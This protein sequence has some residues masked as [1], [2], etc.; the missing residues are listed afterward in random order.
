LAPLP[1]GLPASASRE[2]PLGGAQPSPSTQLAHIPPAPNL[3]T[4]PLP[5]LRTR[6]AVA[7]GGDG[8]PDELGMGH[9][10]DEA[11]AMAAAAWGLLPGALHAPVLF[12][13]VAGVGPSGACALPS[14]FELPAFA[15]A[16]ALGPHAHPLA[17]GALMQHPPQHMLAAGLAPGS[18]PGSAAG[19][20][21]FFN[22][23]A[24][25]HAFGPFSCPGPEGA[26]APCAQWGAPAASAGTEEPGA[27]AGG[28]GGGSPARGGG[29]GQME[30]GVEGG[31][32]GACD[33]PRRLGAAHPGCEG[34]ATEAGT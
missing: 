8:R 31:G 14:G 18:A 33:L 13:A 15:A 24:F 26:P 12:G 7:C 2:V 10:A 5:P 23:L 20:A 16:A 9:G 22:E 6:R 32:R 1:P 29:G 30:D 27:R 3:H 34:G 4:P 21:A 19:G 25:R 11:G 17:A 28:W